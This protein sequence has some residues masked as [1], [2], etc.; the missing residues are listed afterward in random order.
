MRLQSQH[1]RLIA[2]V[3][4]VRIRWVEVAHIQPE[5]ENHTTRGCKRIL[6]ADAA[7][8]SRLGHYPAAVW[9]T[10]DLHSRCC[11]LHSLRSHRLAGPG[12]SSN[13]REGRGKVNKGEYGDGYGVM[14]AACKDTHP[15]GRKTITSHRFLGANCCLDGW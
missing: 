2:A 1:S 10:S 15:H 3:A 5:V 11:L 14:F 8:R 13:V 6:T 12:A 9:D 7:E 4:S